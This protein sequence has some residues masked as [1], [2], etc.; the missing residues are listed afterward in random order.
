MPESAKVSRQEERDISWHIDTKSGETYT[1]SAYILIDQ[2]SASYGVF[3]YHLLA[4]ANDA[5]GRIARDSVDVY[6]DAAGN[7]LDA[8][9]A[10]EMPT[11]P[12][13]TL[14]F[15]FVPKPTATMTPTAALPTMTPSPTA[16]LPPT[17]AEP[18]LRSSPYPGPE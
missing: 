2:P 15:T 1:F 7:Q 4:R 10:R 14:A 12:L 8:D 6:L 16:T 5:T 17:M 11:Y 18:P 9:K 3:S 13:P